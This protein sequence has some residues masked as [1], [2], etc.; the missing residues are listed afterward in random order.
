VEFSRP[1]SWPTNKAFNPITYSGEQ[2]VHQ[3]DTD[4]L[5]HAISRRTRNA[6]FA[7]GLWWSAVP[8]VRWPND[9]GWRA[10]MKP[11]LD[12]IWG[13]R[14]QEI[15]FIGIAPMDEAL[16]TRRLNDCLD[17]KAKEGI[18]E[19]EYREFYESYVRDVLRDS[20]KCEFYVRDNGASIDVVPC[21]L[22]SDTSFGEGLAKRLIQSI[23]LSLSRE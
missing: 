2:L 10:S 12:P 17:G 22:V 7:T 21:A 5:P 23:A 20:L 15:V 8:E 18:D 13:D 16:I 4:Q 14:R 11:Y 9:D 6:S 3:F 19:K 1:I